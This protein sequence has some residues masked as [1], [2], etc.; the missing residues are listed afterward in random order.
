MDSLNNVIDMILGITD[1]VFGWIDNIMT[2]FVQ[3]Q[4]KYIIYAVFLYIIGVFSIGKVRL[5]I[6]TPKK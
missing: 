2:A 3:G 5:N 4:N 1:K 6:T